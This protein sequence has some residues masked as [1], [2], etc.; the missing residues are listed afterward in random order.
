MG[1]LCQ[2]ATAN[3]T[4]CSLRRESDADRDAEKRSENM[5]PLPYTGARL[6]LRS[7]RSPILRV[8]GC[9][10]HVA[11]CLL[12]VVRC[13]P[14]SAAHLPHSSGASRL[15]DLLKDIHR[16][17]PAPARMGGAVQKARLVRQARSH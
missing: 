3:P 6:A 5:P 11:H 14:S 1:P 9:M 8:T 7:C 17:S 16:T 10:E 13:V 12:R 4:I 2:L 15:R